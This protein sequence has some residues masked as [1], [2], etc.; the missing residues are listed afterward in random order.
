MGDVYS[1]ERSLLLFIV[2]VV[3]F[4]FMFAGWYEYIGSLE[5]SEALFRATLVLATIGYPEQ[6][7]V[8]TIVILLFTIFLSHL[9]GRVGPARS[10]GR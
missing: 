5:K 6:A 7:T 3:Q 4:V 10:T 8:K 1:P 2:N 9:I